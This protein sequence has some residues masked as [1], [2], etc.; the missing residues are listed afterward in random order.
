V[1]SKRSEDE[2]QYVWRH[3]LENPSTP[4]SLRAS[5]LEALAGLAKDQFQ[6]VREPVAENLSTPASM[7]EALAEDEDARVRAAVAKNAWTP[8]SMLEALAEDEA[9]DAALGDHLGRRL[10]SFRSGVLK[11]KSS[12]HPV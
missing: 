11:P 9:S 5:L 2:F 6:Y 7:L 4:K 1:C 3:V 8:A 10:A 12:P